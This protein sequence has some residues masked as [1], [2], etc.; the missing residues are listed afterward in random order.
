MRKNQ[1]IIKN[2]IYQLVVE[3]YPK[4]KQTIQKQSIFQKF[5]PPKSLTCKQNIW[6]EFDKGCYR[7]N[8]EYTS[9]T[10]D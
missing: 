7:R 6:L 9:E 3:D 8:C 1:K 4:N 10:S 2:N 5:K